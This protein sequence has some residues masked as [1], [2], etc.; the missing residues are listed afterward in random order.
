MD[1]WKKIAIQVKND[2]FSKEYQKDIDFYNE[3]GFYREET[4]NLDFTIA[5]FIL[6]RLAYLREK[7]IGYPSDLTY[8]SWLQMLDKMILAFDH[9]YN[10]AGNAFYS[11]TM[12]ETERT[13]WENEKEEGL[14]LFAKH[15]EDLWD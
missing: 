10:E 6:P 5:R 15:F 12:T 11:H 4:W 8:E 13:I 7:C 3:N 2:D 1:D 9:I 14:M